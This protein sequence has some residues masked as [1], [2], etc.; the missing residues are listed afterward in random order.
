MCLP[1]PSP[2]QPAS[3]GCSVSSGGV[4]C[5]TDAEFIR[6]VNAT[7]DAFPAPYIVTAALW[8]IGAYGQGQWVNAR[9]AGDH[10]GMS[11]RML[12]EVGFKLDYLNVM[13]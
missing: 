9:P 2:L 7:R 12:R 4:S 8:S 10:T 13:R 3:S 5:G 11:V 1:P 6:V